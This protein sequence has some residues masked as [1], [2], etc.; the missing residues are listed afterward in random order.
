MNKRIEWDER[1]KH[2]FEAGVDQGVLYPCTETGD[3]A[4]GVAWNG[5]TA[6]NESPTGAE[7][8]PLYADNIKYLNLQSV[9]ELE[10]TIEAYTYPDEFNPCQGVAELD[11]GVTIGQQTHR[12]FGL[13]YRTKIGNDT[14]GTDHGYKLHL[15]Y[16]CQAQPTE[17]GHETIN[18]TPDAVTFSW[19]FTTTPV[20]V[21]DHKPSASLVIDST[22]VAKEKM[23]KLEAALYG[24]ESAGAKLLLPSEVLDILKAE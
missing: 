24:S 23:A 3:Y 14:E 20:P 11:E 7:P 10:G 8:T 13:C 2:Y 5:L 22:K 19:S 6:V 15:L 1:G 9:E 12:P 17:Q 18:D 16:G 4:E 21:A